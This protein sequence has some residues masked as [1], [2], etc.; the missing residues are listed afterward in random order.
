MVTW[1]PPLPKWHKNQEVKGEENRGRFIFSSFWSQLRTGA[2]TL[3]SV[4]P[5]V[6]PR[7]TSLSWLA[8]DFP[9]FGTESTLS[10]EP[11]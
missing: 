9:S 7:V 5:S 1:G 8:Q 10:W 2:L 6:P 3:G 11:L 4:G